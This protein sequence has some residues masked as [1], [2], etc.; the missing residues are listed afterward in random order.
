MTTYHLNAYR[1]IFET[2]KGEQTFYNL[3]LAD[4]NGLAAEVGLFHDIEEENIEQLLKLGRIHPRKPLE[5][6][7]YVPKDCTAVRKTKRKEGI[8][9]EQLSKKELKKVNGLVRD[10]QRGNL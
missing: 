7:P 8:R 5:V 1:V 3:R 4:E 10:V 2:R 9:F 6:V